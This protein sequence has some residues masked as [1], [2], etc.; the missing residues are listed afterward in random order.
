MKIQLKRSLK[1]A[2]TTGSLALLLGCGDTGP[3][4]EFQSFDN[5]DAAAAAL[6]EALGQ[7]AP[8]ALLDI[9]GH[10]YRNELVTADWDFEHESRLKIVEASI[11]KLELSKS[12]ED[13]VVM[14]IGPDGWPFPTPIVREGT[15]W[16]F[17]LEDGLDEMID[18][19]V[20]R[21]ELAVIEFL[22]AYVDAQIDYAREDRN[23]D[24]TLQYAQRLAST[25]GK[26]D[27]LYWPSEGEDDVSPFGPLVDGAE[28]YLESTEPGAPLFGYYFKTLKKQGPKR[29]GRAHDYV[30]DG[31]MVAGFGLVAYPADH[32]VTG[33][34]TFVVNHRGKI[35]EK[36]IGP[37]AGMSEY[38]PDD[39]W[40][41]VE[42]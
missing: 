22:H 27:G 3:P 10:Q 20:G 13:R 24:G 41:L 12:G 17:D 29:S 28:S 31:R 1:A 34:M 26:R 40:S 14:L 9:V 35:R 30:I 39:T 36:D 16:H 23:G 21:N 15:S 37:F 42:D 32:G 33:V 38:D 19:R 6:L 7:E 5:P 25:K 8:E 11:E 18:R 2:F 4:P